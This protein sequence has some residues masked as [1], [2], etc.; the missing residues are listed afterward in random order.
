M[1]NKL[2]SVIIPA[3]NEEKLIE[4]TLISLKKQSYR[5]I[6]IIVVDNGSCD[7]T[8]EI[9]KKY[10]DKVLYLSKKGANRAR[11]FG[12]KAA[13]GQ[14]L[15]FMDADTKI[16]ENTIQNVIGFL[17]KGYIG[18]TPKII[19]E[20][21]D[22]KTQLIEGLQNF[23]LNRWK[24]F[25]TPFICM[26]KEVFVNCGGWSESID[27][28]EIDLLKRLSKFGELKYDSN[29]VVKTSSRRFIR[30]KDY[31]YAVLGGVLALQGTK[32]LPL[33][34]VRDIERNEREKIMLLLNK[35]L[36]FPPRKLQFLIG[37]ISE[38]NF[39]DLAK[40]YKKYLKNLRV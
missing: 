11:N 30:N 5:P 2:V 34:P 7:Q 9:A 20:S 28:W 25:F 29:S 13:K 3:L 19:Y 32:N 40:N 8:S 17:K 1:Q 15:T 12:A 39:K 38:N 37:L 26:T 10:A 14:Y 22:Y 35:E 27:F 24:I 6:E 18:V 4:K 36:S 23:C 33:Y 21:K 31:L 16:G